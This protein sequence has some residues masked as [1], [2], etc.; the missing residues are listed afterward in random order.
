VAQLA[1]L[2]LHERDRT[3]ERRL[4]ALEACLAQLAGQALCLPPV[5]DQQAPLQERRPREVPPRVGALN[6]AQ[7]RARSRMPPLLEYSAQGVSVSK[8]SAGRRTA[9]RTRFS[10]V[11]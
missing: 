5:P 4:C 6:P 10:G 8:S 1:L 7:Q 3:V 9:Y 11:V 2:L